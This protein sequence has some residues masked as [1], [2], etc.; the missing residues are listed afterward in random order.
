LELEVGVSWKAAAKLRLPEATAEVLASVGEHRILS[1][2]QVHA[3][4]FPDRTPRRAQQVLAYL[5]RA[6][7]VAFVEARRAPRR[8]YFLTERGAD[9]VVDA[10]VIA[11]LAINSDSWH[12][13]ILGC[14][15]TLAFWVLDAIF[16]RDERLFRALGDY[17]RKGAPKVQPFYMGATAPG[18]VELAKQNGERGS[19]S[20]LHAFWR[21]ALRYLFGAILISLIAVAITIGTTADDSDSEGSSQCLIA[22]QVRFRNCTRHECALQVVSSSPDRHRP[23]RARFAP[24]GRR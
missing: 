17:V 5:E 19:G 11:G 14:L 4:H 21:P 13:A 15:P 8:H 9:L 6:G 7:L 12:L 20:R 2:A 16:L 18:F 24:D 23:D 22:C 1:T 10:G 3:I